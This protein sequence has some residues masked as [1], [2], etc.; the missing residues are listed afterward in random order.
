MILFSAL[1]ACLV[2]LFRDIVPLY[3]SISRPLVAAYVSFGYN[4]FLVTVSFVWIFL[5]WY[6]ILEWL[7][8]VSCAGAKQV[9]FG[10]DIAS[11]YQEERRNRKE[12][13]TFK[14]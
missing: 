13:E 3:L 14:N 1:F 12:R 2:L 9:V 6:V 7:C 8:D 10:E 11:W 4:L 5:L